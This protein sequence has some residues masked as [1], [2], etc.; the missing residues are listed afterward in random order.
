MRVQDGIQHKT[1]RKKSV[2]SNERTNKLLKYDLVCRQDIEA[3]QY[4]MQPVI[5]SGVPK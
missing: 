3:L 1:K 5:T 4:N 2:L